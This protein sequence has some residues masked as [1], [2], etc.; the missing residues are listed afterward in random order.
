[1]C[2]VC[3]LRELV[4]VCVRVCVCVCVCVCVSSRSGSSQWS[5]RRRHDS[6]TEAHKSARPWTLSPSPS[7]P[8]SC[9]H[10]SVPA[11]LH[12]SSS[13]NAP[14][15]EAEAAVTQL[16]QDSLRLF[17]CSLFCCLLFC[18]PL[19]ST[20]FI[21]VSAGGTRRWNI[22]CATSTSSTI[23][24]GYYQKFSLSLVCCK[25]GRGIRVRNERG[26]MFQQNKTK[27][28]NKC[29]NVQMMYW[30]GKRSWHRTHLNKKGIPRWDSLSY[31]ICPIMCVC[32]QVWV[33]VGVCVQVCV[34]VCVCVSRCVKEGGEGER[35]GGIQS[36]K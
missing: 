28:K 29:C 18:L 35:Q 4:C 6:E 10:L 30:T 21:N 16:H 20:A 9:F 34:C 17:C 14:G 33:C 25:T 23:S 19:P 27:Q 22:F 11:S 13:S 2:L 26:E 15:E 24:N 8:D 5:P 1:M 7:P 3:L 36:P 12:P 31:G 32:A